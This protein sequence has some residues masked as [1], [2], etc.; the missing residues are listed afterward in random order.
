MMK[1]DFICQS[2]QMISKMERKEKKKD[3]SEGPVWK[4]LLNMQIFLEQG[5]VGLCWGTWA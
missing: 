3:L 2:S 4:R 1:D 5:R